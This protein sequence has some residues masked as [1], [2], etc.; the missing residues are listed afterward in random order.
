MRVP[1][2]PALPE[3]LS[4][5]FDPVNLSRTVPIAL[6]TGLVLFAINQLG[7]VWHDPGSVSA[8]IKSGLCFVVPFCVS[9]LGVL[10]TSRAGREP[11]KSRRIESETG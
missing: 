9:N 2:R 8:W 7:V 6:V 11:D 10:S 4:I 1:N 5:V 3:T